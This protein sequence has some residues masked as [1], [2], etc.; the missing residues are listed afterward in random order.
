[1]TDEQIKRITELREQGIG[2]V[3]IARVL[4]LSENTVKSYCQ[5]NGYGGMRVRTEKMLD[6]HICKFC[7]KEVEQTPG[8]K[9][10]K[11]CDATCRQSWWNSHLDKV[12]RKAIYEFEC[13]FCHKP[14]TAYG[15]DHR[16]YCCKLCY[17]TARYGY[18]SYRDNK[19]EE[20]PYFSAVCTPELSG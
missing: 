6:A 14:F 18:R 2:Y 19:Y 4:G 9:E 11:F 7:G 15:N 8:H 20:S 5:R 10:K 17:L 16:K 12:N 3:K 13:E 1:M